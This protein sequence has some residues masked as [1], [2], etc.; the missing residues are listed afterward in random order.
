MSRRDWIRN[1]R[2]ERIVY[3]PVDPDPATVLPITITHLVQPYAGTYPISKMQAGGSGS[4]EVPAGNDGLFF[5]ENDGDSEG[6]CWV[7]TMIHSSQGAY[8]LDGIAFYFITARDDG[9]PFR[10]E[11]NGTAIIELP[12]EGSTETSNRVF[13]FYKRFFQ[14]D[15]PSN[16]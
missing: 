2:R 16:E 5:R 1:T 13:R 3:L 15:R 10:F 8:P 12:Q 11:N 9:G 4:V 6:P 7:L 14:F